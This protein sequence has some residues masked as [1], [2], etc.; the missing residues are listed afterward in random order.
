M[1]RRTFLAAVAALPFVGR[2]V[3]AE[4]IPAQAIDIDYSLAA[5]D[6]EFACFFH[7]PGGCCLRPAVRMPDG[8]FGNCKLH[9]MPREFVSDDRVRTYG[10][11]ARLYSSTGPWYLK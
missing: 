4:P 8:K 7:E 2:L 1:N 11:D 10:S 3:K 6:Y 9:A 5:P